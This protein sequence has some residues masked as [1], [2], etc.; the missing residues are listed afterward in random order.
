MAEMEI[1][2]SIIPNSHGISFYSFS[3]DNVKC[4]SYNMYEECKH[5]SRKQREKE[6]NPLCA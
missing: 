5:N 6:C 4:D 2:S 3:A 1:C